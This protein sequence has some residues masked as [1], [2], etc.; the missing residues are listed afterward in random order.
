MTL[1]EG[2]AADAEK[3]SRQ[4]EAIVTR[5]GVAKVNTF[6]LVSATCTKGLVSASREQRQPPGCLRI[7]AMTETP[8]ETRPT[9]AGFSHDVLKSVEIV[10]TAPIEESCSAA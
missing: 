4:E 3:R 6:T 7:P 10:R 2:V 1:H 5:A 8:H 9:S